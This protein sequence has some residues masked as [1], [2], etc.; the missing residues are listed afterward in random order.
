MGKLL[1]F[2]LNLMD[3]YPAQNCM[4]PG[5]NELNVAVYA[6]RLGMQAA[7]LGVFGSDATVPLIQEVLAQEMVDHSRC[8]HQDGENGMSWVRLQAGERIFTGHNNGGVTGSHPPQLS[9]E[10][11]A[12]IRGFDVVS[13]SL[14][15]RVPT[16]TLLKLCDV[17]VP[18]A[19]D[20]SAG[21]VPER[22]QPLLGRLAYAFFSCAGMEEEETRALLQ[23]AHAAGGGICVATLGEKGALLYNGQTFLS[24]A[25]VPTRVVDTL[26]AGD[27]FIAA[28]LQH[29]TEAQ[30]QGFTGTQVQQASLA[31]GATFAAQVCGQAG[32]IGY[33]FPIPPGSGLETERILL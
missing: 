12:Y 18:L 11:L 14:Y 24:Q 25:A 3:I 26:G 4:Y 17:G 15:G 7:F 10:D 32:A 22:L 21:V 19:Y 20:F 29:Q 8:R 6:S 30:K 31:K 2:G 5:G 1:A 33:A 28:F 27:S 23:S 9:A 16:A 13:T